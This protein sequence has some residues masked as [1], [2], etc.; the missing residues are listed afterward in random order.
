M[1][2]FEMTNHS[3]MDG[4]PKIHIDRR[5]SIK[6]KADPHIV[7]CCPI[8]DKHETVIIECSK[9]SGGC[10]LKWEMP[11]LMIPALVPIQWALAHMNLI[12]PLNTTMSYLAEPGR[13]SAEA[14]QVMTQKA[15]R[16]GAK[17]ILYWDDDT[18]PPQLGLYTM[19]NWMERHPEAGAISGVYTTREQPNE[20]LVYTK[21]GEGAAWD[22]PM[23]PGAQPVPIFGAGAG[24]LLVRVEAILAV[25]KALGPDVPIWADERT[26]PATDPDQKS[27][28]RIMWGHDVRFCYLLNKHDWP[29]YVHGQVLCQHLD[30]ATN[31]IFTIPDDTP[32]FLTQQRAN[33]NT[34]RYWNQ[35]YDAE[36]ANT[37]RSYDAMWGL[38]AEE[39]DL[40]ALASD[41][42]VE[43]G[44]GM[45][46]LGSMFTAKYGASWKGYDIST[47]AVEACKMR[48][49]NAERLDVNLLQGEHV[50]GA[51]YVVASEIMEHLDE[52]TFTH[53]VHTVMSE[54]TVEK[55]IFTVPDNCMGPD[56]VPE[57]TTLFNEELVTERL[58]DIEGWKLTFLRSPEDDKHLVCVLTRS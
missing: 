5:P 8:G 39:L 17:Y 7:V 16:L 35:L 3:V 53:V 22:F 21:H 4:E 55:F 27:N 25:Q 29:V 45:G 41:Y 9:D 58:K 51:R 14:R 49:L 2:E 56:E 57:H 46:V 33:I 44:C 12:M 20:P 30:I 18:L 36:G 28:R 54:D 38:V 24:F 23:G 32:G 47:A 1:S 48:F 43:L 40:D 31:R 19:H 52:H 10:G 11:G 42:V 37:W 13:L 15:I 34:E 6:L 26:I 50:Q